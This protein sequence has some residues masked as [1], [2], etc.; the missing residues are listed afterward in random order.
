VSSVHDH[1]AWS[2]HEEIELIF[3]N[4]LSKAYTGERGSVRVLN[5][6]SFEAAPGS[7]FTLLGPR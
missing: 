4:E 6:V 1:P 7:V 5:A 2:G 3:A